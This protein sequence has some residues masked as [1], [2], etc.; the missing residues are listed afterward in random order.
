MW[1]GDR[2]W[3]EN[4][5]EALKRESE[6]QLDKLRSDLDKIRASVS[7]LEKSQ[8]A[9]DL[10]IEQAAKGVRSMLQEANRKIRV[11]RAEGLLDPDDEELEIE[12]EIDG[13]KPPSHSRTRDDVMREA[14]AKHQGRLL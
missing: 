6:I 9:N 13:A 2:V 1:K 4:H 3:L 8:M 14:R 7:E 12:N 10:T 11:A 5:L